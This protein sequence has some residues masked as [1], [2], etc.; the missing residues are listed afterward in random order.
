MSDR[1]V[2]HQD[3]QEGAHTVPSPPAIP[4][5]F[6][7]REA[8]PPTSGGA[9]RHPAAALL[10]TAEEQR[11]ARCARSCLRCLVGANRQS[12]QARVCVPLLCAIRGR[13][14]SSAVLFTAPSHSP[15]R[16]LAT[17]TCS[18][19]A[20]RHAPWKQKLGYCGMDA[21]ASASL[22]WARR[23]GREEGERGQG[24]GGG[25]GDPD[26]TQ[27]SS[28]SNPQPINNTSTTPSM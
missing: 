14:A 4:T 19:L 7:N 27:S 1:G 10:V 3:D 9:P 16:L 6:V 23:G 12:P 26:P 21:R 17:I 22:W 25:G 24:G 28:P 5:G 8:P 15:R 18:G 11:Q 13:K 20:E 2:R